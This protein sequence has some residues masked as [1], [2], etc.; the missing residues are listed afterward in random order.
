LAKIVFLID[1]WISN[2]IN[3]VIMRLR[4]FISLFIILLLTRVSSA[5]TIGLQDD[6][7]NSYI[8]VST[9]G[10]V[11]DGN[12]GRTV[13]P[14]RAMCRYDIK[15]TKRGIAIKLDDGRF[16]NTGTNYLILNCSNGFVSTKEK[17]YRGALIVKRIYDDLTV[18][19][20]LSLEEYLLGVVPS[21]MPSSWD[22]EALKAQAIAARSYA[23]S[24]LGKR[25][26]RGYDLKDTPE[27][28]AYNGAT[29][30]KAKTTKAVLETRGKVLV[31]NKKVINAYYSAS[32]GGKTRL[33]SEAW[34]SKDLPYLH[35][36]FSYDDN[37]GKKGHGVGL[38]QY[39]ANS[40]AK[41]GY[42]AYQI[43]NYFYN[44]VALGTIK[45]S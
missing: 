5:I 28:Q 4:L 6:V 45:G 23:I 14:L 37:V 1:V 32:A 18:I 2:P 7:K 20:D 25:V 16:Y 34:G 21:E 30:E 8:A 12:T 35:S 3:N 38:S 24:N 42:N 41:Q 10:V 39:G 15:S 40:L 36:V 26:S 29:G 13:M 11:T 31:Y 17:W 22:E 44:Q 27:D 33:P 9:A 43:L 19:N